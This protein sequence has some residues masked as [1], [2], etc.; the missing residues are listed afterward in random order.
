M[1]ETF[2]ETTEE[3]DDEYE[4]EEQ[5]Q[6]LDEIPENER[7]VFI[8][9]DQMS[10]FELKRRKDRGD[11]DIHPPYQREEVWTAVKKSKLIESVLRSIPV[12]AIYLAEKKDGTKEVIDGQ[13]R[14]LAFFNFLT[15][16]Y[17]LT[18][19]PVLKSHIGKRFKQLESQ[20]QRKIED[21]Q[22]NIFI[23]KKES[24]PDIKFDVFQRINQGATVLNAQEIRQCIYRGEGI[25][26]L[27]KMASNP[28]F[29]S[30]ISRSSVQLKRLKDK[31]LIL[32][33]LSFYLKGYQSY[34]GNLNSFLNETLQNFDH[35]KEELIQ[36]ES[37]FNDTIEAIEGV[38]GE[39]PFTIIK[40]GK[41]NKKLN[42]SLFDLLTVSFAKNHMLRFNKYNEAIS[43]EFTALLNDNDFRNAI[44]SGTLTKTNVKLRFDKWNEA[45][46]RIKGGEHYAQ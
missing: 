18:N 17:E 1:F 9:K 20:N 33:F 11:I 24:H 6:G 27:R 32:R 46:D 28:H 16:Q 38:F 42:S 44:T 37:I 3:N 35:Y 4:E 12:P 8:D 30:I 2:D 26:L 36:I 21:Y 10:I 19:L 13:Q 29:K 5:N 43:Q 45:I 25:E 39:R 41:E 31:E 40:A 7:Q 14:L 23:I 34:K 22:L 15:N